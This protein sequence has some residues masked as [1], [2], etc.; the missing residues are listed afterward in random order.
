MGGG[1][2]GGEGGEEGVFQRKTK[3]GRRFFLFFYINMLRFPFHTH[4]HARTRTHTRTHAHTQAQTH[5]HTHTHIHT[6]TLLHTHTYT[7]KCL[8][9]SYLEVRF[10]SWRRPLEEE[11]KFQE[12][13]KKKEADIYRHVPSTLSRLTEINPRCTF[14]EILFLI[15]KILRKLSGILVLDSVIFQL[16]RTQS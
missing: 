1:E 3:S 6:H 8:Q 14:R 4:T 5:T 9:C 7:H 12:K 2:G 16:S 13:K 15:P 11:K 10:F